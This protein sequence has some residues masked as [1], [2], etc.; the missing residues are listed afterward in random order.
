MI[1]RS[2]QDVLRST[3]R[4][5]SSPVGGEAEVKRY[6][7]EPRRRPTSGPRLKGSK[8]R[9]ERWAPGGR[10]KGGVP[11]RFRSQHYFP[12]VNYVAWSVDTARRAA[13]RPGLVGGGWRSAPRHLRARAQREVRVDPRSQGGQTPKLALEAGGLWGC[14]RVAE[15]PAPGRRAPAR[16][17]VREGWRLRVAKRVVS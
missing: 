1:K 15:V 13:P 16:G 7:L 5:S 11:K 6:A 8:Y 12:E 3:K 17:V 14:R 9:R 2:R 4:I 10:R